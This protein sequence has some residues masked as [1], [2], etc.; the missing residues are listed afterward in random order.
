MHVKIRQLK[1]RRYDQHGQII[2]IEYTNTLL[3]R[4]KMFYAEWD[5]YLNIPFSVP[6]CGQVKPILYILR[7]LFWCFDTQNCVI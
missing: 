2:L 5:R 3:A 6:T 7:Q 4:R 1:R